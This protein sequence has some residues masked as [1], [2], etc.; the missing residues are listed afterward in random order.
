MS[1][2]PTDDEPLAALVFKIMTDPYVGRLAFFRV[3][4]GVMRTGTGVL[5]STKDR[6]ERIGRMVRMFADKR[7]DMEEVHAGDIAAILGLKDTFT[8]ETLSDPGSTRSCW[9]RSAS[10]SR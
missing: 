7:E 4:S 1:A 3:Y 9:R 2:Q 6:K 8:G 5:N 10:R